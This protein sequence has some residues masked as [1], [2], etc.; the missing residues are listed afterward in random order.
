MKKILMVLVLCFTLVGCNNQETIKTEESAPQEVV[1]QEIDK[2]EKEMTEEEKK[3]ISILQAKVNAHEITK[4]YD[5]TYENY[6]AIGD[7]QIHQT[8]VK[9]QSKYKQ[10]YETVTYEEEKKYYDEA[11]S[12]VEEKYKEDCERAKERA[13]NKPTLSG[14]LVVSDALF[15][16]YGGFISA[17]F[18]VTN[19]TNNTYTYLEYYIEQVDDSG[20]AISRSMC[21]WL[22]SLSTYGECY[23]STMLTPSGASK[24][25]VVFSNAY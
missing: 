3:N 10:L 6:K 7:W 9:A 22:G 12:K 19:E 14:E 8:Y 5:S 13:D 21:N 11:F 15:E 23:I 16:D 18:K 1:S 17:S 24:F 4:I 25:R 2:V 20:D